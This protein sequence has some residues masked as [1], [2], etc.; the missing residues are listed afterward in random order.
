[1]RHP[2][3]VILFLALISCT[4]EPVP[5][6]VSTYNASGIVETS[7]VLEGSVL[8][9]GHAYVTYRA[10]LWGTDP[11]LKTYNILEAG[12]GDGPVI[13]NLYGLTPGTQYYYRFR[14]ANVAGTSDGEIISFITAGPPALVPTVT[15]ADNPRFIGEY[16]VSLLANIISDGNS[17]V[18]ECGFCWTDSATADPVAGQ[19]A[20]VV[21]PASGIGVYEKYV[22]DLKSNTTYRV[23]AWARNEVGVAYSEVR[24]FTTLDDARIREIDILGFINEAVSDVAR[25]RITAHVDGIYDYSKMYLID[26]S[27][28]SLYV[29]GVSSSE[30]EFADLG[31]RQGDSVTIVGHRHQDGDTPILKCES[32]EGV[33]KLTVKDYIGKWEGIGFD[34]SASN[35]TVNWTGIK[36]YESYGSYDKDRRFYFEGMIPGYTDPSAGKGI[37]S[38]DVEAYYN[39]ESGCVVLLGGYTASAHRVTWCYSSNP[40]QSYQSVFYPVKPVDGDWVTYPASQ[41]EDYPVEGTISLQPFWDNGQLCLLPYTYSAYQ[42]FDYY[43]DS[44]AN[45]RTDRI[46]RKSIVISLNCIIKVE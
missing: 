40:D 8:D 5:P 46:Y 27:D 3:Y 35:V 44:E 22:T 43:F 10:F 23:C 7:A 12:D 4:L 13:C 20:T 36:S 1:M 18:T 24:T 45:A 15:W 38:C 41:F 42:V 26:D 21:L 32:V 19:D 16:S 6:V 37:T 30:A 39:T 2:F 17:K 28:N 31:I 29:W 9:S 25:Y 33:Y 34:K 11:G 14:A